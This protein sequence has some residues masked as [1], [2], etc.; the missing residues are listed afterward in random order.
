M[1]SSAIYP[2]DARVQLA[3]NAVRF[4]DVVGVHAAG[5]SI[6]DAVGDIDGV[7]WVLPPD[8][9]EHRS[10]NLLLSD[11]GIRVDID[12]PRRLDEQ[13]CLEIGWAAATMNDSRAVS[14]R[15]FDVV[16]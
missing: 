3:G 14:D 5:Q 10:E 4:P 16:D 9:R 6:S 11:P 1:I 8:H 7:L 2:D 15:G 13:T 12:Q